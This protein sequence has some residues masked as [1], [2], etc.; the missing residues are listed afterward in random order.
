MLNIVTEVVM[1]H[2]Q[3]ITGFN[4]GKVIDG[5]WKKFKEQA[6]ITENILMKISG[7][8]NSHFT[9]MDMLKLLEELLIVFK[10]IPG[11]FLMPCLLSTEISKSVFDSQTADPILRIPMMLHFQ[12]STARI[13]IF[14]SMVCKLIS[15]EE[16]EHY[17][18]SNVARNCFSFTHPSG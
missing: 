6:I 7:G 12:R 1:E 8:Y 18:L 15:N 11:E 10:R 16:L 2:I 3:L 5:V 13:G 4:T 17:E 14:C 9:P